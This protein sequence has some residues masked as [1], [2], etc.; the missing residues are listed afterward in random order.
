MVLMP[1]KCGNCIGYT[2]SEMSLS[3]TDSTNYHLSGGYTTSGSD[4]VILP[5]TVSISATKVYDGS[6]DLLAMLPW[7]LEL[8]LKH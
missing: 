5:M 8:H 7:K 3:G 1:R 6:S 4:G 2:V